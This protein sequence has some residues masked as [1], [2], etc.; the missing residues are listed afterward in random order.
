MIIRVPVAGTIKGCTAINT[1]IK[2]RRLKDEQVQVDDASNR[3]GRTF[4]LLAAFFPSFQETSDS[5]SESDSA[6]DSTIT[7]FW[8]LKRRLKDVLNDNKKC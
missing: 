8:K 3:A 6:T 1:V 4:N 7:R 5:R 2:R